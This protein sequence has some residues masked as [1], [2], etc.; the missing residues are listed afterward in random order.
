VLIQIWCIAFLF[1][2][3]L[4]CAYFGF[5]AL[6]SLLVRGKMR[7][8]EQNSVNTF[9]IIIPAH[10][11]EDMISR[12][13][14]SCA[15][16]DYPK[17]YYKVFVIADNC[18]DRTAEVAMTNGA[19]CL[20]RYDKNHGGKGHALAWAF[21]RILP[22]GHDGV[23]VVDADCQL[24]THALR[25]FD[26]HL[27][28]GDKVLQANDASSNP[29]ESTMSYAVAVGNLIENDLFYAP[30]SKIGLAV[31]LRGTGMVFHREVLL[32]FPWKA[33]SIAE[34]V[35][36]TLNLLRNEI[37]VRF[38][39]DVK[40]KSKFP[41]YNYQ[42]DIQRMRWASGALGFAKNHALKL[43]REGFVKRNW[44]LADAGWTFLVLS[45][46]LVLLELFITVILAI[47]CFQ[48]RPGLLSNWLLVTA[49]TLVFI[50][51]L[52]FG[53]G[54]LSL[55]INSRRIK[56][57][58]GTPILVLRLMVISLLGLIGINRDVWVR[59]PR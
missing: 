13:L 40:V 44:L 16:L 27:A 56:L 59:T 55:G 50:Q 33:L 14:E 25:V 37:R 17:D 10:N 30:K 32:A 29:D 43:I 26:R 15:E 42:L 21:D 4:I 46:P 19:A 1:F 18:S 23:V 5:L 49:L 39:G 51:G 35:E 53:A 12:V 3:F 54:I 38:V 8:I 31:F 48:L 58:L 36:Y 45:R 47:L 41:A 2:A 34:D 28:A 11:E 6:Y 9:A 57:L 22:E 20:K 52:Y 7:V 24:D